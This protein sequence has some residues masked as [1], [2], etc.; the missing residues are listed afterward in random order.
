V[1]QHPVNNGIYVRRM[2]YSDDNLYGSMVAVANDRKTF[3]TKRGFYKTIGK[4]PRF[5]ASPGHT[6]GY[7]WRA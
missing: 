5:T 1:T 4:K 7:S 3:W 6:T 2:K